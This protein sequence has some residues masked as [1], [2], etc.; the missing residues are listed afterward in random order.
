MAFA[1]S[2]ALRIREEPFDVLENNRMRFLYGLK[3]A[4]V[5]KAIIPGLHPALR[6][7][8]TE[9]Q[10]RKDSMSNW[11]RMMSGEFP[12]MAL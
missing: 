5:G 2:I 3:C 1:G 6:E 4:G 7:R 12:I 9:S 11:K 10:G 8:L